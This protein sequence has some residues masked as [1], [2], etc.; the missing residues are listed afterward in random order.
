MK[1]ILT[2]FI[3]TLLVV[4][5]IIGGFFFGRNMWHK[6]STTT[7]VFNPA[8]EIEAE[9][10]EKE[11]TWSDNRIIAVMID[12][13]NKDSR[14]HAGI[15]DAFLLY[16][17]YVEGSATRIMALFKDANT[18]KIGPVRSCRHYF[19]DYAMDN[20]AIYAHCG[21]SP[22]GQK[23][24]TAFQINNINGLYYDG[25]VFWRERKYKGDWHSLYTSIKN[26]TKCAED[27]GYNL[28]S[29]D[30]AFSYYFPEKK[31]EGRSATEI[32]LPYASFYAVSYKYNEETNLYERYINSEK[33]T[34]QAGKDLKARQI[35]IQFAKSYPIA[36]DTSNRIQLET[37]GSGDGFFISDGVCVPIKWQRQ[38][39]T[40][41]LKFTFENGEEVK[42]NYGGQTYVNVVSPSMNVSIKGEE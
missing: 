23:D 26:L 22:N 13:D 2:A 5:I 17:M 16:E 42:L 18:E 11:P 38:S 12:N 8:E 37:V 28:K 14:P 1:K 33:H 35:I 36:G 34:T 31:F 21:Q 41:K 39:R 10:T 32:V 40:S 9:E 20:G 7:E 24:L 19:L 4:A 27:K 29:S 3:I 15:E 6:S 30:R 25:T